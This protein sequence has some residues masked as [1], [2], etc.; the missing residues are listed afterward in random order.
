MNEI[1]RKIYTRGSS[2]ETT[3]PRPLLFKLDS[4]KRYYIIF[5]YD[6]EKDR[7]YIG[8]EEIKKS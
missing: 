8:F 4:D 2:F 3:L 7:W 5:S 1:R 6:T